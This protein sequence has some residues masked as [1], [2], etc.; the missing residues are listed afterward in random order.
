VN[1]KKRKKEKEWLA[2][3]MRSSEMDVDGV[4]S[5]LKIRE[6]EETKHERGRHRCGGAARRPGTTSP[7]KGRILAK[8]PVEGRKLRRTL[9]KRTPEGRREGRWNN[10]VYRKLEKGK[11]GRRM[12]GFDVTSLTGKRDNSMGGG[13]GNQERGCPGP[14][15]PEAKGNVRE[16][17]SGL[18]RQRGRERTY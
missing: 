9:Q 17:G 6:R 7:A 2:I 3:L 13:R 8:A 16:G 15:L 4:L 18:L 5:A 12:G 14:P 1:Q 11:Q 10:R